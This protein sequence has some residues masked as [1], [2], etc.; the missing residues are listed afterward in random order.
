MEFLSTTQLP[1]PSQ[2]QHLLEVSPPE[3]KAPGLSRPRRGPEHH[4]L[5][6]ERR[7]NTLY[8]VVSVNNRMAE[9]ARP[10]ADGELVRKGD[11]VPR[12]EGSV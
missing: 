2:F 3:V 7:G 11:V 10:Q 8:L 9:V 1:S 12:E 6:N 5:C 4:V